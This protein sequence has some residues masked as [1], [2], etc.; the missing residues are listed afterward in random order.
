[1]EATNRNVAQESKQF[2]NNEYS[3]RYLREKRWRIKKAHDG[4]GWRRKQKRK[5]RQHIAWEKVEKNKTE[6]KENIQSVISLI[7]G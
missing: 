6:E 7:K 5:Y 3:D 2:T 4:E 1:M